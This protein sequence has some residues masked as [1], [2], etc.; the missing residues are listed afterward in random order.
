MLDRL[1]DLAASRFYYG[2]SAA[3]RKK[4]SASVREQRATLQDAQTNGDVSSALWGTDKSPDIKAAYFVVTSID[5]PFEVYLSRCSLTSTVKF[6]FRFSAQR[7]SRAGPTALLL[8]EILGL[9]A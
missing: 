6:T 8:P 1:A 9:H 4:T 5:E 3:L 2:L 7:T